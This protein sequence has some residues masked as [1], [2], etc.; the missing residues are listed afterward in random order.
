MG[1]Y[2]YEQRVKKWQKGELS[3]N[4]GN[5]ISTYV[6]KYIF[7]KYNNKCVKCSWDK[8]NKY[9]NKIPLQVHHID[10]NNKNTVEENL[11]LLCPNCHSLTNNYGGHN[12]TSRKNL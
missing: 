11:T 2:N 10:G 6:R 4:R 7:K 5:S 3:G 9:T 8:T 1:N 12:K